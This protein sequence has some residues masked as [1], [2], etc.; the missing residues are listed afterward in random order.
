M[1]DS[2]HPT[3]LEPTQEAGRAFFTRN[4]SGKIVMLNLLRFRSVADY[5]ATPNLAPVAPISGA[6]AY[7]LYIEHTLPHLTRSGGELLFLGKGGAFLI[8]PSDERWDA[9]MLVRQSSV[10]AFM[11]FASNSEYMTGMGHRTAALEDSR[12]LP[13]VEDGVADL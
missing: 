10:S 9:A 8:G 6:A 3:Y 11:E 2:T 1:S 7:R 5:S 4:I 13:L 12:L